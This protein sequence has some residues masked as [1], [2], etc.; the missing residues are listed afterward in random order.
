MSSQRV[1]R[2]AVLDDTAE[3]GRIARRRAVTEAKEAYELEAE[4]LKRTTGRRPPKW[5]NLSSNLR[6]CMIGV[7]YT[8]RMSARAEAS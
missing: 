6:H 8:G 4:E 1:T 2:P 7:F 5:E 3:V